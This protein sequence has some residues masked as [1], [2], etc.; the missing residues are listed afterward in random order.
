M[1]EVIN[2]IEMGAVSNYD[3]AREDLLRFKGSFGKL[4]KAEKEKL[5]DEMI[6][7]L[8]PNSSPLQTKMVR[9]FV[10]PYLVK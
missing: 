9:N 4:N 1:S 6:G 2:E 7:I 3:R 8:M 5:V 10:K